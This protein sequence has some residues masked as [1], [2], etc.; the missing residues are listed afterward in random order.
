MA[1]SRKDL[2]LQERLW[3]HGWGLPS[4]GWGPHS[5]QPRI[6]ATN[7]IVGLSIPVFLPFFF[8]NHEFLF[9]EAVFLL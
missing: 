7:G 8:G 2:P 3:S 1:L 4:H 6:Q 5:T 9:Y